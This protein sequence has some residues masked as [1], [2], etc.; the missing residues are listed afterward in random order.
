METK[1]P[2]LEIAIK[3][4]LEA[5]KILE[6]YFETEISR[7]VK[8]DKSILTKV[9]QEAEETIKKIILEAFP[10]HSILGEETG[11]TENGNEYLWYIDPIDGTRNFANHIPLFAVSIALLHKGSLFLGVVYNP[12]T[13]SL[14][15]GESGKGAYLNDNRILVSKDDASHSMITVSRGKNN[16]DERLFRELLHD[17][18]KKIVPSVRDLGCAS[19]DLSYVACGG[20][21]ADIQLGLKVYDFAAG[22][23]LIQEAGG[24]ITTLDGGPWKFPDNHF[25]ASNGVFHD[26]LVEEIKNQ[27]AKLGIE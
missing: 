16:P 22:I 4:A 6:K 17:F 1:S 18:P 13:D 20:F 12:A 14:F 25:I 15:Y 24:K 23:L 7:T 8:E 3:A 26:I 2:E 21:E 27:K 9:D 11:M 10:K 5:G 19:L